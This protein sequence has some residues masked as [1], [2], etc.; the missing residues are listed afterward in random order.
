[1]PVKRGAGGERVLGLPKGH[2][3]GDE[4][5]EE[6]ALREVREETGVQVELIEKLG[7]VEYS[8][9]RRGRRRDKRV[10]F[11]LCEYRSGDVADHDHE[12]EEA[13]WMP[14]REALESLS[15]DGERE[16]V[17]RALSRLPADR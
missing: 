12:I 14:M 15:Y 9:E 10:A 4:T 7:D 5:P 16:M 3:D 8:Y 17:A 2:P 1:M 13:R 6:A 11:F